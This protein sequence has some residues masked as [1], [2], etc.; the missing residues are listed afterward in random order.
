MQQNTSSQSQRV[1]DFQRPTNKIKFS[2]YAQQCSTFKLNKTS[3]FALLSLKVQL[4]NEFS[5]RWTNF[6]L[7][8]DSLL[9]FSSA[10][11]YYQGCEGTNQKKAEVDVLIC[12]H[13]INLNT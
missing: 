10:L 9:V 1:R 8:I 2:D 7:I 3:A 6:D 12:A 13:I 4:L 11:H 5:I